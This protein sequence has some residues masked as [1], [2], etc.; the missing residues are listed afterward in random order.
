ML[1]F[2]S[3]V[4]TITFFLD[5]NVFKISLIES[6]DAVVYSHGLAEL[7]FSQNAIQELDC[8][9]KQIV[10]FDFKFH[11][12]AQWQ[13]LMICRRLVRLVKNA[14]TADS[15]NEI[16]LQLCQLAHLHCSCHGTD[17]DLSAHKTN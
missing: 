14:H 8:N 1:I 10:S 12:V 7:H 9:Y 6:Y 4:I 2:R 17:G 16:K 5:F 13:Q 11:F 15:V 3:A